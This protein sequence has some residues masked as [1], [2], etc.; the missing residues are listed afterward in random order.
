MSEP[1]SE[2]VLPVA[3]DDLD[4]LPLLTE[5]VVA[6]VKAAA[7]PVDVVET[8]SAQLLQDETAYQQ[9]LVRL[10]AHWAARRVAP[11]APPSEVSLPPSEGLLPPSDELIPQEGVLPD[12]AEEGSA[13]ADRVLLATEDAEGITDVGVP[14]TTAPTS[15]N[16][17]PV[18]VTDDT[19]PAANESAPVAEA[20]AVITAPPLGDNLDSP[21]IAQLEAQL[22]QRLDEKLAALP[23]AASTPTLSEEEY[24]R[25]VDRLEDHL[26]NLLH[27]KLEAYLARIKPSIVAQVLEELRQDAVQ[28]LHTADEDGT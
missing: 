4:D 10:E 19:M 6:A 9:L 28:L 25:V 3:S 18:P 8:L 26:E 17:A 21:L 27:Q 2:G 7:S 5:V 15:I 1:N 16:D 23:V 14:E 24:E 11:V 22:A 13:S 20:T 12:A